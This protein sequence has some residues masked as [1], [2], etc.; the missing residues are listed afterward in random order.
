[1]NPKWAAAG[2]TAGQAMTSPVV[3]VS[4]D[5]SVAHIAEILTTKRISAVPVVDD[6][7]A[8]LGLVSERDLLSRDGG[9]A[10][11][12]MT[13]S[14]ISVTADTDLEQ[15]RRLLVDSPIRRLPVMQDGKLAGIISR[16]DLVGRMVEW[17]CGI[18]GET[19]RGTR[20]PQTCPKCGGSAD[21]FVLQEQPPGP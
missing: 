16:H 12:I 7:G 9:Y 6:S 17:A 20:P 5:T 4:P 14:V 18:C 13:T 15:V 11:D 10:R 21:R 2:N 3:T 1:M 19:I 8:V